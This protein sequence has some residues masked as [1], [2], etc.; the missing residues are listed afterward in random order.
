MFL[1][2]FMIVF[3]NKRIDKQ[4]KETKKYKTHSQINN[5]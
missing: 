1:I 4:Q 2:A 5:L 3:N